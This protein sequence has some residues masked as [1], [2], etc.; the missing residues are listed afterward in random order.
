M[1]KT[2]LIIAGALLSIGLFAQTDSARKTNSNNPPVDNNMNRGTD[3]N[4]IRDKDIN[5]MNS[6]RTMTQPS[7]G[8]PH[9]DGVMMQNGKIW[10]VQNG[11][12]TMLDHDMR[13]SNGTKIMRN[14][15]Y[16]SMDGKKMMLTEGQ[17][18]DMSGKII[19]MKDSKPKKNDDPKK[20]NKY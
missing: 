7:Q 11:K 15:S 19:M 6:D 2:I 20:D 1:K 14:G 8:K 18:M 12:T 13:M 16:T 10:M 17:H 3:N 4:T 5:D 9:P